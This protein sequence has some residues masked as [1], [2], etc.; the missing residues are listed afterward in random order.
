MVNCVSRADSR[1]APSQWETALLCNDVSHW[2]SA[3]S[4]RWLSPVS[5]VPM[6]WRY[7]SLALSHKDDD[8]VQIPFSI[9]SWAW[10]L[11]MREY[12]TYVKFSCRDIVQ[13]YIWIGNGPKS[14]TSMRLAV[15]MLRRNIFYHIIPCHIDSWYE[16][17]SCFHQI[18]SNKWL[19]HE[20]WVMH[21]VSKLHHQLTYHQTSNIRP[22]KSQNLN[23]SRLV[24]KL[25]LPNPL[26]P[27]AK[28]R[29]ET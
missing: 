19:I 5:P 25:F 29:M 23:V 24:F 20:G 22:T 6:H 17:R 14:C 12:V 1:F 9:H 4:D 2:L 18:L 28:S 21:I 3:L 7:C 26:K 13:P 16:L 27:D 15:E 10:S 11:P 8:N